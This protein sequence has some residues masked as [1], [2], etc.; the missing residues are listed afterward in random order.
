MIRF[1][2]KLVK[3]FTLVEVLVVV[4]VLS[5]IALALMAPLSDTL[6][7]QTVSRNNNNLNDNLQII[8][9][10]MDKEF[11]TASSP[12]VTDGGRTFSFLDQDNNA[13]TYRFE[14]SAITKSSG[15]GSGPVTTTD[16]LI[17]NSAQFLLKGD[18]NGSPYTM[19]VLLDAS[20][21]DSRS[22]DRSIVQSTTVLRNE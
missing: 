7:Y 4:F 12:Q 1:Y 2:D 14:N 18:G 5:I 10:V 6:R 19:T 11:R 3:G 15:S 16:I 8:L 22:A 20:S 13:I 21:I 9:N 17:V